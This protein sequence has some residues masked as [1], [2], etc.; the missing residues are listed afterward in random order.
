MLQEASNGARWNVLRGRF[1]APKK[2]LTGNTSARAA[3]AV[4]APTRAALARARARA[5]VGAG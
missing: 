1:A 4:P 2:K 5:L 3:E